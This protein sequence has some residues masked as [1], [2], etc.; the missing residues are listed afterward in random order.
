WLDAPFDPLHHEDVV[1]RLAG[2]Q[3]VEEPQALLGKRE[4][5]RRSAGGATGDLRARRAATALPLLA[6][7]FEQLGALLPGEA[8][9]VRAGRA[10]RE[11][12]SRAARSPTEGGSSARA[13]SR[14]SSRSRICSAVVSSKRWRA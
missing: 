7:L 11:G 13:A 9:E 2:L 4:W 8:G 5:R 6:Q 10:H 12:P 1:G 3:P 14:V